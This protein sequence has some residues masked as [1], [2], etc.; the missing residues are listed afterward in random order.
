MVCCC[1]FTVHYNKD[2]AVTKNVFMLA[3]KNVVGMC[4]VV[5]LYEV[6]AVP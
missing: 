1:K 5:C 3:R 6:S 4:L 2:N